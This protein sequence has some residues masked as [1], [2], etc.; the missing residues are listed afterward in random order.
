MTK[1]EMELA[2]LDLRV[3]AAAEDAVLHRMLG[4]LET[5]VAYATADMVMVE[6]KP[7]EDLN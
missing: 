7:E 5:L 1:K 3:Q 4:L 6:E 2:V